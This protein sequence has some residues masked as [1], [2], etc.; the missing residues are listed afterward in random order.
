[1]AVVT[2]L[3]AGGTVVSG[4]CRNETASGDLFEVYGPRLYTMM[5]R[6][7]ADAST[8]AQLA[9]EAVLAVGRKVGTDQTDNAALSTLM[10]TVARDLRTGHL[11]KSLNWQEQSDER[12]PA[13]S[14]VTVPIDL[15]LDYGPQSRMLAALNNLVPDQRQIV[16]LAYLEGLSNSQIAERVSIPVSCIKSSL[17][18]ISRQ[19][20]AALADLR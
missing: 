11:H 1:M 5:V 6:S 13:S 14:R 9:H 12:T 20:R 15:P 19:V 4:G 10:F 16:D 2:P 3:V 18:L 8:A 7:G 17:R